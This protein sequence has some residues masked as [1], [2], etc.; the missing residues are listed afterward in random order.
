MGWQSWYVSAARAVHGYGQSF[1]A[2]SP[3]KK[4]LLARNHLRVVA[5]HASPAKALLLP[6]ALAVVRALVMP[7]VELARG[8]PAMAWAHLTSSVAGLGAA[9]AGLSR[10]VRGDVVP[11]R[12]LP[13][14]PPPS[15]GPAP[16]KPLSAADAPSASPPRRG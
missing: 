7:A 1:G 15:A 12:A 2:V 5:T 11:R 4:F 10:R 16:A 8:R 3:R 9:A 13:A 14:L 6:P